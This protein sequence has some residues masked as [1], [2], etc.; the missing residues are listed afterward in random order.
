MV[1]FENFG[2]SMSPS[3]SEIKVI[4][5]FCFAFKIPDDPTAT[6]IHGL[7]YIWTELLYLTRPHEGAL[8]TLILSQKQNFENWWIQKMSFA[9]LWSL[10]LAKLPFI[11]RSP[12]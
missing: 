5:S 6:T 4:P 12:P 7:L 9:K 11:Y 2:K 3:L 10:F 8:L 1:S